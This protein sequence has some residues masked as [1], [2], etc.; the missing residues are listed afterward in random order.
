[1]VRP[2][3]LTPDMVLYDPQR[4]RLAMAEVK[5]TL[6]RSRQSFPIT[7][8]IQLLDLLAKVKF[9]RTSLYVAYVVHTAIMSPSEFELDVLRL[10]EV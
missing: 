5:T 6:Q 2:F 9:M 1:M 7:V 3:G 4:R 10:E 8:A